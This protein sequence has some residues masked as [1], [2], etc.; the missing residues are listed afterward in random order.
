LVPIRV[1]TLSESTSP[2]PTATGAEESNATTASDA[3]E[4]F[5]VTPV[6]QRLTPEATGVPFF[7]NSAFRS[8]CVP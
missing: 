4:G 3:L 6:M 1:E 5:L 8:N 7:N 2:I